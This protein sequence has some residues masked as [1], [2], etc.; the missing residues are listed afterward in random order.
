MTVPGHGALD[1]IAQ[2]HV[3]A[4]NYHWARSEILSMPSWERRL[5]LKLV[6]DEHR[7]YE[8]KMKELESRR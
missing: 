7:E 3:L 2:V 5:Y 1:P 6:L 4:A 8:R